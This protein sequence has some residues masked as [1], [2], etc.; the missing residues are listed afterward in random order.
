MAL[1]FCILVWSRFHIIRLSDW[2][3]LA[4]SPFTSATVVFTPVPERFILER[5]SND[6]ARLRQRR[7]HKVENAVA[8]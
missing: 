1:Y 6:D 5:F 4:T 3:H 2:R 7:A 8:L